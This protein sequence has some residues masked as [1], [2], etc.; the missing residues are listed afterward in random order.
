VPVPTRWT[1]EA[2]V[3][4][5]QAWTVE[6]GRAPQAQ[7]WSAGSATHPERS[8]VAKAFR[9]AGGWAG[10]L[11]AAGVLDML[12]TNG[13]GGRGYATW[14]QGII[15]DRLDE[16]AEIHGDAP[17]VID[18]NPAL[19]ELQGYPERAQVFRAAAGYWPHSSYVSRAFGRWNDAL[20]DAGLIALPRGVHRT[21]RAGQTGEPVE[22]WT[23]ERCLDA[24]REWARE[25]GGEPPRYTA[26]WPIAPQDARWPVS[27]TVA[28]ACGSFGR[29]IRDAGYA[30]L[31]GP[32]A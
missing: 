15:L 2:I 6:Q 1:R 16:W 28:R 9:G 30:P 4:A 19:A 21:S 31:R 26:W 11:F 17:A 5:I 7:D 22:V 24:I 20:E 18:W 10:A 13:R 27:S 23:R 3:E 8:T 32:Y 25:H 29:A 12:E 14:T